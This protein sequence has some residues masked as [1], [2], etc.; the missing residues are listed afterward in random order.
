MARR[1]PPTFYKSSALPNTAPWQL[2]KNAL[3]K[4]LDTCC[5]THWSRIFMKWDGFFTEII[6]GK[7]R[8]RRPA[9]G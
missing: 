3:V 9:N 7:A 4:S 8:H 2:W 1:K 6:G 5:F